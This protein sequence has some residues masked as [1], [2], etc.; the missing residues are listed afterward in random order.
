M[1]RQRHLGRM[2]DCADPQLL[3]VA[4][5]NVSFP[6]ITGECVQPHFESVGNSKLLKVRPENLMESKVIDRCNIPT[7]SMDFNTIFSASELHCG[8]T[9]VSPL[10]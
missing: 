4:S 5:M 6:N 1:R 9:S 10:G 8:T 7:V 3:C 2:R